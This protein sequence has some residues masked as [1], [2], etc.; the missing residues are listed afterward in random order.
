MRL[1][2]TEPVLYSMEV[3]ISQPS[4]AELLLAERFRILH[5]CIAKTRICKQLYR[6]TLVV[7][8]LGW[9]DLDL[10]CSTILLG[11]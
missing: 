8:Y 7:E 4:S 1:N 5:N 10:G 11:Q 9:V 2:G 3:K 6:V